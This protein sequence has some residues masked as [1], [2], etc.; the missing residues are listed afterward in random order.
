MICEV[1]ADW[2][3]W[4]VE[5]KARLDLVTEALYQTE[6]NPGHTLY[7][8]FRQ[9]VQ[10]HG[11]SL[12]TAL[13]LYM[14]I[15]HMNGYDTSNFICSLIRRFSDKLD[16]KAHNYGFLHQEVNEFMDKYRL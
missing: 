2:D 6:Y 12:D 16:D 1:I 5:S 8:W 10:F 15:D 4:I 3:P 14:Q 13:S 9:N 7:E 11:S